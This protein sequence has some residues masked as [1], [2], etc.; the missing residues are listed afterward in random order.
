MLLSDDAGTGCNA[1]LGQRVDGRAGPDTH[2]LS[3][4]ERAAKQPTLAIMIN[5]ALGIPS[6]RVRRPQTNGQASGSTSEPAGF[7]I[8]KLAGD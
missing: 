8:V 2:W 1:R 3:C 7:R 6:A 5:V 4:S